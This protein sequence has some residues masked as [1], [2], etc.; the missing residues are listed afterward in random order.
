MVSEA[1]TPHSPPMATPNSARMM[2]KATSEGAR[3]E[4][5]SKT[6]KVN[7]LM[8]STGAGRCCRPYNRIAARRAAA[9][10]R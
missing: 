2:M 6:V 1:P 3:P 10:P 9:P 8:I 7:T 5:N 4:A